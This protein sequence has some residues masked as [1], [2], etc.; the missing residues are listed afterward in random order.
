MSS[1]LDWIMSR[2]CERIHKGRQLET[3]TNLG[4]RTVQPKHMKR[5]DVGLVGK[6]VEALGGDVAS[7]G[8]SVKK[9]FLLTLQASVI[10]SCCYCP[11]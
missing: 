3:G 9:M 11:Y 6:R 4:L 5:G 1:V 2:F 8:S 10:S 7:G